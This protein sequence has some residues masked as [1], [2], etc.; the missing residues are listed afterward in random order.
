MQTLSN[1]FP[2]RF[3]NFKNSLTFNAIPNAFGASKSGVFVLNNEEQLCYC[4]DHFQWE[5]LS[6][7]DNSIVRKCNQQIYLLG[8]IWL[9]KCE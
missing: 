8:F 6:T 7:I 4:G 3:Y 9:N 2:S 1:E 5:N